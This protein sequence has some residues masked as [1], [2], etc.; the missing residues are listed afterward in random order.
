MH[1]ESEEPDATLDELLK[2]STGV[3]PRPTVPS[4]VR[5]LKMGWPEGRPAS[6]GTVR[7]RVYWLLRWCI[8]WIEP[9]QY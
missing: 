7:G 5:N 3:A 8:D 2:L 4:D 1:R 9:S 6:A